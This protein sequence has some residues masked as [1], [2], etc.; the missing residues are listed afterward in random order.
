MLPVDNKYTAIENVC[1]WLDNERSEEK[2]QGLKFLRAYLSVRLHDDI[3]SFGL[4]RDAK[5]ACK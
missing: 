4:F 3:N 2:S 1:L 5:Q